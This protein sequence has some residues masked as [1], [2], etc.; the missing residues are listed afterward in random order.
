MAKEKFLTIPLKDLKTIHQSLKNSK[1]AEKI[2]ANGIPN[3]AILFCE[4]HGDTP[5]YVGHAEGTPGVVLFCAECH[6]PFAALPLVPDNSKE[7][8]FIKCPASFGEFLF[9]YKFNELREVFKGKTDTE[10]MKAVIT[11]TKLREEDAQVNKEDIPKS[12]KAFMQSCEETNE[13]KDV[14]QD[15]LSRA[16]DGMKKERPRWEENPGSN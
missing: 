7:G 3:R 5:C 6:E 10:L 2:K 12:V 1:N 9:G 15:T 8:N 16:R 4:E 13:E 14:V 11:L